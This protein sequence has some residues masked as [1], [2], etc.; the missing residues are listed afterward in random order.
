MPPY[1]AALLCWGAIFLVFRWDARTREPFAR[2]LWVPLL[3]F[4]ILCSRPV[5]YWLGVGGGGSEGNPFDR[6]IYLVFWAIAVVILNRAGTNWGVAMS[7]NWPLVL[8]YGFMLASCLWADSPFVAFKRWFKDLTA[9][10]VALVILAQRDPREALE[11]V[12]FR[13]GL[14]LFPVSVLL[15]KYFPHH[16]RRYTISGGLE[17]TGITGQKNSLGEMIMVV[18]IV[19][20]WCLADRARNLELAVPRRRKQLGW[21]LL[22]LGIYLLQQ[23]DSKTSIVCLGIGSL[24]VVAD[25]LPFVGASPGRFLGVLCSS[26]VLYLVLDNLFSIRGRILEALGRDASLTGRTDI[27]NYVLNAGSDPLLGAGY[28]AFWENHKRIFIDNMWIGM[29]TA[30]SGYIDIYLDGGWVGGFFL[31][32]ML[33]GVGWMVC[34]EFLTGSHF[35]RL[36]LAMFVMMLIYN[37]S[38]TTFARRSPMWFMFLLLCGNYARVF[39]QSL[40]VE[41]SPAA[42]E[43]ETIRLAG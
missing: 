3:W 28:M 43:P 6:N 8:L 20:V 19:L 11:A 29:N 27:W 25:R 23:S 21:L 39:A 42:S 15:I 26:S 9:V 22:V 12:F 4:L 14:V 38:E 31:G 33:L 18:S 41:P 34:R 5:S 24:I 32:L 16:G 30:H 37:F 17:V 2:A 10:F 7:N 1:L 35:G 13:A 36:Q 40:R